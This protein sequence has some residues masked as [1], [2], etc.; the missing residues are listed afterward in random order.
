MTKKKPA[1]KEER[2]QFG[3]TYREYCA[4]VDRAT[5]KLEGAS[6][7]H[8]ALVVI[9]DSGLAH[10]WEF[11]EDR[12]EEFFHC[13]IDLECQNAEWFPVYGMAKRVEKPTK[14]KPAAP[15]AKKGGAKKCRS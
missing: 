14:K 15:K 3:Q 2:N 5:R 12:S 13:A 8:N 10:V 7:F 4:A 9:A 6:M 11:G 1:E